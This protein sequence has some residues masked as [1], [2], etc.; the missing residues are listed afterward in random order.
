MTE[1]A[2]VVVEN[3]PSV[4]DSNL[5]SKPLLAAPIKRF[6]ASKAAKEILIFLAFIA[7]TLVMTWPWILHIRDH[8][9]DP[10]DPYLVGWTL[11]WDYY[12]TFHHPLSF[13]QA[14]IFYPYQYSLAFRSHY[15]GFAVFFFPLF[16]LGVRPLTIVGLA[17]LLGF[18]YSG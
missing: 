2:D 3:E 11:W 6:L 5:R 8:V 12:G 1:I 14:N 7:L 18:A 10:G 16:A 15:Y 4:L 9:S 17:T 13:F